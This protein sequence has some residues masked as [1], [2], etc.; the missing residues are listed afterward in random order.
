MDAVV[1]PLKEVLPPYP[2]ARA[3]LRRPE[4]A[5]LDSAVDRLAAETAEGGNLVD[6]EQLCVPGFHGRDLD[7]AEDGTS[8]RG[9]A[10]LG[11]AS[12]S[13]V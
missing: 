9:D 1:E 11:R 7:A 6:G 5:A 12:R 3:A 13:V 8:T 2:P 4:F 10:N